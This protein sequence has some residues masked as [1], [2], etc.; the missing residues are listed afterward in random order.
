MVNKPSLNQ[1]PCFFLMHMANTIEYDKPANNATMNE[2]P[3]L[4]K[5]V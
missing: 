1:N 5:E 4:L 3:P 2:T